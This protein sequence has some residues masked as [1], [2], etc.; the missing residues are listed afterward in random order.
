VAQ[1]VDARRSERRAA[2]HDVL[3]LA[4]SPLVRKRPLLQ[5][6]TPC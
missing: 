3:L 5:P 2:R 1:L 4:A 6:F